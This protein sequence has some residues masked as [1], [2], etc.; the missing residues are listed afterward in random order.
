M[1]VGSFSED[2]TK[3]YLLRPQRRQTSHFDPERTF[4]MENYEGNSLLLLVIGAGRPYRL[5]C[6]GH[7]RCDIT[8]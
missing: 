5:A 4:P 2:T 6:P 1:H 7:D 3:G 8:K